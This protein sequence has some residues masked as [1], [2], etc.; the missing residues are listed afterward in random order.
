MTRFFPT[1]YGI[2][3]PKVSNY[4]CEPHCAG[5]IPGSSAQIPVS[6]HRSCSSRT[7]GRLPG[8]APTIPVSVHRSCSSTLALGLI[9]CAVHPRLKDCSCSSLPERILLTVISFAVSFFFIW[10][11]SITLSPFERMALWHVHVLVLVICFF[12]ALAPQPPS[13]K[14]RLHSQNSRS[15]RTSWPLSSG[16]MFS[17]MIP[18]S[19]APS[20]WR[21]PA[22]L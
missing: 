12:C 1:Q 5:V 17:T 21:A 16:S 6:V 14:R 3:I 18:T 19:F 9:L 8:S 20:L 10:F 13:R 22:S 7:D 4:R 2:D 11:E 15:L